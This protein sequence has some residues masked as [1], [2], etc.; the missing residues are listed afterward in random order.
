MER[1]GDH[2]HTPRE[3]AAGER[4]DVTDA[5]GAAGLDHLD[6]DTLV[7]AVVAVEEVMAEDGWELD[8]RTKGQIVG[9]LYD[10]YIDRHGAGAAAPAIDKRNVTRLFKLVS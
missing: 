5:A 10:I 9:L 8:P 3:R 7:A 1:G 2:A 4:P 6:E